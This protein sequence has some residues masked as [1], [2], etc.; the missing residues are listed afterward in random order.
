MAQ[1]AI[2]LSKANNNKIKE[3][4]DRWGKGKERSY[5][6]GRRVKEEKGKERERKKEG[7]KKRKGEKGKEKGGSGPPCLV[8]FIPIDAYGLT[9]SD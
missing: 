4:E 6:N 2:R 3:D 7:R 8:P 5:I 9:F 1:S